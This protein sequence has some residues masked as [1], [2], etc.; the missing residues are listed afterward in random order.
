ML[1]MF[2]NH[3]RCQITIVRDDATRSFVTNETMSSSEAERIPP[4]VPMSKCRRH[5]TTSPRRSQYLQSYSISW[6]FSSSSL[7]PNESLAVT[8]CQHYS[9]S[10]SSSLSISAL[11]PSHQFPSTKANKNA[12]SMSITKGGNTIFCISPLP[13]RRNL[14]F[15]D[16]VHHDVIKDSP[17]RYPLR[18]TSLS[19]AQEDGNCSNK[20]ISETLLP[21]I[22]I[23]S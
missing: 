13:K 20:Y 6:K 2:P 11:A 12:S 10:L 14:S 19:L 18:R 17:P 16:C 21:T 1:L 23:A 3:D 15:G 7:V 5:S 22:V 8:T 4:L 9:C